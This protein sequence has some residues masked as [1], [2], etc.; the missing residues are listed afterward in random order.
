MARLF[1]GSNDILKRGAVISTA[2]DNYTLCCWIK[3]ASIDSGEAFKNGVRAAG[4]GNGYSITT[5]T[6]GADRVL[7][8][9]LSFV[10]NATGTTLLGT[11]NW[12]HA[13]AIRSS[14]TAYIYVDGA[15][16]GGTTTSAPN[17]PATNASIGMATDATGDTLPLNANIAE[18][19]MWD[20]ALT[21]AEIATLADGFSP[22]FVRPESLLVYVP[23]IGNNSPETDIVT[24]TTWAVTE[25]TK[26]DH[27]RIIYPYGDPTG[28]TKPS[29][30]QVAKI[31]GHK[32]H[33]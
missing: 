2:T 15:Q 28:I 22:L 18:C 7:R 5:T 26:A 20:V 10:A 3:L 19:A 33:K 9:D 17:T 12:H 13:V 30:E 31:I 25:A 32:A 14:G 16:E 1:D 21:D 29:F 24:S 6:S 8:H 4:G 11:T 27:P 23:L